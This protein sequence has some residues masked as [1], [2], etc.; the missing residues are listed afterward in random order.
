ML[1]AAKRLGLPVIV[2]R[3]TPAQVDVISFARRA[4]IADASLDVPP[5][6]AEWAPPGAAD[7]V[8]GTLAAAEA[9]V[10]IARV[11][12][13]ASGASGTSASRSTAARRWPRSWARRER[14][15]GRHPP[16]APAGRRAVTDLIGDTPIVRLRKFERDDAGRRAVG[17]VRVHEPGRVGQGSRRLPD[18]PRRHPHRRAQARTDDHRLDQRQ[19]RRRLLAHRRRARLP[20]HAG[21][22][23]QRLVGAAQDHPGLRHQAGLL[24][25]DGGVRRR[26]SAVPQDG[27][28]QPGPILLPRPVL[29]PV[30]PARPLQL[31]RARD[32][33][34]DRGARH[35]LRHRHR[36]D[37]HG[38]GHRAAAEGV[39]ARHRGLGRRAG[40]RAAR[41]RGAQAHGVLDRPGI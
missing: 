26:D 36:H 10:R 37:R 38:D 16:R 40:R 32:L 12:G 20:R 22:A 9:L 19:H 3:A 13:S 35:P 23:R 34:A 7:V 18:D 27:R 30:E 21:D 29:E 17:Q 6:A 25:S 31:D 8:A 11:D 28:G 33:G 41:P 4:P 1:G 2:A 24:R 15:D 14:A 39:P 5:Q